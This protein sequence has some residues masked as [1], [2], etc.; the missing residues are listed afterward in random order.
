MHDRGAEPPHHPP[1]PPI[2]AEIVPLLLL[3][4]NHFDAVACDTPT[5]VRAVGQ[6]D[7][8]MSI[9]F[10]RHGIDQIYQP[11]LQ[12]SHRKFEDD[13]DDQRGE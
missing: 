13:M 9:L 12:S 7:N 10:S 3:K 2:N 8:G 6:T 1:R 11:I 5:E 4:R